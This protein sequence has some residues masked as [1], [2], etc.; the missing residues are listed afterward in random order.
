MCD[1][2]PE[3]LEKNKKQNTDLQV[4]DRLAKSLPLQHI[5]PGF[6]KHE[7][8]ARYGQDGNHQTLLHQKIIYPQMNQEDTIRQ[9]CAECLLLLTFRA[10]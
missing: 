8:A 9:N 5:V 4:S 10:F 3:Q 2:D 6:L 1:K 7:L